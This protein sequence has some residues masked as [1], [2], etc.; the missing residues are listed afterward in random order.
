MYRPTCRIRQTRRRFTALDTLAVG[1]FPNGISSD[2]P[3]RPFGRVHPRA[4]TRSVLA[5]LVHQPSPVQSIA[6][7]LLVGVIGLGAYALLRPTGWGSRRWDVVAA[8]LIAF[9]IAWHRLEVLRNDCF[10][11][12]WRY[13]VAGLQFLDD[14]VAVSRVLRVVVLP[15]GV[16]VLAGVISLGSRRSRP[17]AQQ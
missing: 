7:V 1:V 13:N 9:A 3:R 10:A 6:S 12:F 17:P 4:D 15:A 11:D 16:V 14:F 2:A 5:S 8:G